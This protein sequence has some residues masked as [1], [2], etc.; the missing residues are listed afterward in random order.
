MDDSG[1]PISAHVAML[2]ASFAG[3]VTSLSFQKWKEMTPVEIIM[4]IFVGFSFAYFVTPLVAGWVL[5]ESVRKEAQMIAALT[6]VTATA[7]NVL[8]PR[9]VNWVKNATP[10]GGGDE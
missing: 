9:L 2:M 1:S 7:S 8:I 4:A 5:G 10:K 6:Y 3:A